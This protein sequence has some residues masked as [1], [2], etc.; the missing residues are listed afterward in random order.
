[1]T[2]AQTPG[3]A[4]V[5]AAALAAD[6]SFIVDAPAG[7]G[8]TTLLIQRYLRLLTTV[9]QPESIVAIT[10]TRKAAEEMRSRILGALKAAADDTQ[11]LDAVTRCWARAALAADERGGWH[12]LHSPRRLR[13]QTID[14]LAAFIARRGPLL[15][16]YSG[17][18]AVR[19]NANELY[20]SA[21][22]ATLAAVEHERQWATPLAIVL[23][24]LDNDWARLE[25]LLVEMLS[26]RDQWLPLVVGFPE[27]AQFEAALVAEIE[28]ALNAL[29]GYFPVAVHADVLRVAN[30]GLTNLRRDYP[31]ADLPDID[32]IGEFPDAKV[33]QREV[34]QLFAQ[35]F[36]TA[37][38]NLRKRVSKREGFP[39]SDPEIAQY[40][41][42]F[43][44]VVHTLEEAPNAVTA[45]HRAR[46]L[47]EPRYTDTEWQLIEALFTVLKLAAAELK[48]T[49]HREN[50]V[51]F[52][53]VAH[54]ARAALG[55]ADR[56]SE[57]GLMLDYQIQHLLI[58][59]FQDTSVSQYEMIRRLVAEWTGADGR[60]VFLVG[61]P[62]QSIYRF[63]QADVE[64]FMRTVA[65][66][67]LGSIPLRCLQLRTNFRTQASL[68]DWL[69]DTLARAGQDPSCPFAR[70]G[71]M[72]AHREG[73]ERDP[74]NTHFFT[75]TDRDVEADAVVSIVKSTLAMHADAS[76]GILVRSRR[77][78]GS[79][80]AALQAAGVAV[81][82][83]DIERLLE[84]P[85]V[86]D[87][88]ALTRALLHL[89]DRSAWLAV[90]RAP[91]CGLSLPAMTALF[92]GTR[93]DT[94]WQLLSDKERV[95]D[96]DDGERRALER[97][98]GL[99]AVGI[100]RARREPIAA[101]VER[102]WLDL[103]GPGLYPRNSLIHAQSY[104]E[105]LGR[106][107]RELD[108]LSPERLARHLA[109]RYV[110]SGLSDQPA[111]HIMTIHH[112]KGLEFDVVILPGLARVPRADPHR[113]LNWR[114]VMGTDG[115]RILCA[116]LP[117][118]GS[119][120]AGIHAYLRA[121]EQIA[122]DEEVYRLLYV[123]LTRAREAI[124]LLAMLAPQETAA[125]RP[126]AR[127]MLALLSPG[128]AEAPRLKSE[129]EI[130]RS[131]GPSIL[132]TAHHVIRR[133]RFSDHDAAV[134]TEAAVFAPP[135]STAVEYAWARPLAK[136]IGT[137]THAILHF[138]EHSD[139]AYTDLK[140][141]EHFAPIVDARL[142][143][144]GVAN[145]NIAD[146]RA[147][148][149]AALQG[150]LGS[151]RGRWIVDPTHR[152][153][154]SELAL[155]GVRDGRAQTIIVDRTF[156]DEAECR[157]IIDFKTGSHSG[158]GREAFLDSEL[159]RH[160]PQLETYASF[161]R[162][163]DDRPIR[164]GLFFP[165]LDAW[166]EWSFAGS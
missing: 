61:D 71:Q 104:F 55:T 127:S 97:T 64:I 150:L 63:R 14:S 131:D 44:S 122:L 19:E 94:I 42:L 93:D 105:Q 108:A 166:R 82:S 60:T 160:R 48:L 161:M 79:M 73:S 23:R 163:L 51:D 153:R 158:G 29:A 17:D 95:V 120:S 74:V 142:R 24:Y 133:A 91:W 78:L 147:Q 162:A 62:M 114:Q 10:F 46:L 145:A 154:A 20:R 2:L 110:G 136:H 130:E 148:V 49:F 33:A 155:S 31:H 53:E 21:S 156:V 12:L 113:L 77:H 92:E 134:A 56:P 65:T 18:V 37:T 39:A 135:S 128:L 116:S 100:A 15:S 22:K 103:G 141:L 38:G 117:G 140:Q 159:V 40:R 138:M 146:A 109:G 81:M 143:G 119:P 9:A 28:D 8:K 3:D 58:D 164:L 87:L 115:P 101:L 139:A 80:G 102:V 144:M 86:Q 25:A 30:Y 84:Q 5:R 83:N 11:T 151:P 67:T 123:A 99:L 70:V 90:L 69:N 126:P 96:L 149:I 52:I 121:V 129:N 27:R 88:L 137:V 43:L 157:W 54:A 32:H 106:L 13:V 124:H 98:V 1:M 57:L 72:L 45:L 132:P 7:S 165:L 111:V 41:S 107:A 59:E 16:G 26:R 4:D 112:A 152:H 6:Q 76:I 125:I 34:W 47:P 85:I 35:L 89:A 66:A 68:L 36:L 118:T 50:A 75:A